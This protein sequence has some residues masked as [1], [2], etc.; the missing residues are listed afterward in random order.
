[1]AP[2][3]SSLPS[4][5]Q[6]GRVHVATLGGAL[7]LSCNYCREPIPLADFSLWSPAGRLMSALC[8]GCARVTTVPSPRWHREHQHARRARRA[9]ALTAAAAARASLVAGRV[10]A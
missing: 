4:P 10:G 7:P 2:S 6:T 8:A 3:F 9:T 1:M 5:G